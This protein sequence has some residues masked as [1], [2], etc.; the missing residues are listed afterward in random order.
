MF[1]KGFIPIISCIRW[2]FICPFAILSELRGACSDSDKSC[3]YFTC[4]RVE[5]CKRHLTNLPNFISCIFCTWVFVFVQGI[6]AHWKW[7]KSCLKCW[8]DGLTCFQVAYK[9]KVWNS[10]YLSFSRSM[11]SSDN[12]WEFLCDEESVPE[13]NYIFYFFVNSRNWACSTRL[14]THQKY[15]TSDISKRFKLL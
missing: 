7:S 13:E 9:I 5:V 14:H 12:E 8:S 3:S 11:Y 6:L 15:F 10:E 1:N 2:R 4:L